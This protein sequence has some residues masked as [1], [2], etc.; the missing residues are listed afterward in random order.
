MGYF[1]NYYFILLTD[2]DASGLANAVKDFLD[3]GLISKID[4]EEFMD[5]VDEMRSEAAF[6]SSLTFFLARG[7]RP[8]G[9]LKSLEPV[10]AVPGSKFVRTSQGQGAVGKPPSLRMLPVPSA[11]TVGQDATDV[12]HSV[13]DI[14]RGDVLER[15]RVPVNEMKLI[16]QADENEGLVKLPL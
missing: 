4:A 1:I 12:A 16:L 3:Q 7:Y 5:A 6:T 9:K 15:S 13:V 11:Q 10:V 14:N 8:V 2:P